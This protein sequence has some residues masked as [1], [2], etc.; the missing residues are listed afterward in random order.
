MIMIIIKMIII[1]IIII[2]I[3]IIVVV[4]VKIKLSPLQHN[5]E[6]VLRIRNLTMLIFFRNRQQSL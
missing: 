1:T 4:V 2:I 6:V 5:Q 3:I